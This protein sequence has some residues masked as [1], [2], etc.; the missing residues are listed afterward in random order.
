[1]QNAWKPLSSL[2]APVDR[3]F[4]SAV[5]TGHFMIVWGGAIPSIS[6]TGG[7]YRADIDTWLSPTTL[8]GAP[9]ERQQHAGLWT[10]T[11]MFIWGGIANSPAGGLYQ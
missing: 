1:V 5:W 6:N 2:G 9:A 4:H 3:S 10:G 11:Q 8:T 7:V